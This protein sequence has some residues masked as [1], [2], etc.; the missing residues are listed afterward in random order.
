VRGLLDLF[1]R[2][3]LPDTLLDATLALALLR[4]SDR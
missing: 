1:A 4:G 2:R 3:V